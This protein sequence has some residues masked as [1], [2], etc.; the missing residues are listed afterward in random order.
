[1]ICATKDTGQTA[2]VADSSASSTTGIQPAPGRAGRR[3]GRGGEG[4]VFMRKSRRRLPDRVLEYSGRSVQAW[5][6]GR[7]CRVGT[8][9]WRGPGGAVIEADSEGKFTDT[10]LGRKVKPYMEPRNLSITQTVS[11]ED[12][13][14]TST[15]P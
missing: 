10:G 12:G 14:F 4:R 13:T 3:G 5:M 9:E 2:Q 6:L 7:G 15:Y 1:M 8:D 11:N